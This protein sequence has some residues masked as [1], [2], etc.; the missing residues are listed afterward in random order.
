[1]FQ[2]GEIRYSTMEKM[3]LALVTAKKKRR[4][5]FES[6]TIVMMTKFHIRKLFSK[7]NLFGLVNKWAIELRV[8]DI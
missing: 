2:N 1:M 6:H 8:Y 4:H 7:P 5:Y 3:V